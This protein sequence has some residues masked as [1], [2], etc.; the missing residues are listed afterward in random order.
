MYGAVSGVLHRDHPWVLNAAQSGS[1]G[2]EVVAKV[3][4][5]SPQAAAGKIVATAGAPWYP[6]G[7]KGPGGIC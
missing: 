3:T 2:S 7:G 1:A 6:K 5:Y 4:T